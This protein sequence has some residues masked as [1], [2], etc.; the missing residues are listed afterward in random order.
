MTIGL[1]PTG[2]AGV[3]ESPT[4][5]A[6]VWR[7]VPSPFPR[8]I[9]TVSSSWFVTARS[10]GLPLKFPTVT[11]KGFQPTPYFVVC[12]KTLLSTAETS[13]CAPESAAKI[14]TSTANIELATN[15]KT[16]NDILLTA[17]LTQSSFQL[18]VSAM[19]SS[20]MVFIC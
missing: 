2:S 7:K 17:D 12:P 19:T 15:T 9:E 20:G 13:A 11:E 4:F 16:A 14:V 3:G 6:V 1:L 10:L 5:G 18:I 8:R